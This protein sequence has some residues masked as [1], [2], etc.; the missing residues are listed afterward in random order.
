MS[1]GAHGTSVYSGWGIPM[2]PGYEQATARITPDGGLELRVG[3]HSHGQGL[4][5]TL[6]QVANQI[7]G[8]AHNQITLVHGDTGSTPYSTGTW[9]SRCMVMAGGAVAAAC[10]ELAQRVAKIGAYLLQVP[11][12]EV[13]VAEGRVQ[14][15][16]GSIALGAVAR[17]WYLRP[18]DLP[19]DVDP[20]GLEITAGYKP[21]RDTGTFSYATHA[22]V[23]AVDTELGEVEILDYVVVEDR[24]VLVNP[25]ICRRPD[26][27]WYRAGYRYRALRGDAI[28]PGRAAARVDAGGLPHPRAERDAQDTYPAHGNA[29]ALYRVR[30]QGDR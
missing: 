5:T 8:I 1:K 18:Q 21:Q 30:R 9:G 20:S 10:K 22:V 11:V 17:A 12:D 23:V 14:G 29:V 13:T 6:S 26:L 19:E 24:G 4:E 28:R 2:V 3:V 7:L 15:S 25:M 27:W 16:R